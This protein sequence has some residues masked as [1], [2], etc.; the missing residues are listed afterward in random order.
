MALVCRL[1]VVVVVIRPLLRKLRTDRLA[2]LG[3][4]LTA[5]RLQGTLL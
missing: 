4:R 2:W 3:T 5:V 1:E